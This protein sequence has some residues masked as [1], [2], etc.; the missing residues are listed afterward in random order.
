MEKTDEIDNRENEQNR[1][2]EEAHMNFNLKMNNNELAI[3]QIC[4][5]FYYNSNIFE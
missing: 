5:C 1:N 3:T 2:N 4:K